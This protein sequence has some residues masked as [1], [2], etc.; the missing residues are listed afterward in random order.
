LPNTRLF[1]IGV[2]EADVRQAEA[3][4][5]L[6]DL[7]RRIQ[8]RFEA[9][10]QVRLVL[11]NLRLGL[12][13]RLQGDIVQGDFS[14][15]ITGDL[16]PGPVRHAAEITIDA[17]IDPGVGPRPQ[18]NLDIQVQLGNLQLNDLD[19]RVL[20]SSTY[21]SERDCRD[22][23]VEVGGTCLDPGGRCVECRIACGGITSTAVNLITGLLDL[24]RPV[25]NRAIRPVVQNLIGETLRDLNGQP[26]RFEGQL[27][28]AELAGFDFLSSSPLGVYVGPRSGRFPVVDRNGLGMEVTVNAGAEGALAE[29]VGE[30]PPFTPMKGPV[31]EL[32]GTDSDGRPYH[33]GAT[34]AASYFNQI[35]YAA[36]RSGSLCLQLSSEDVR[37]L[38]NG[39]F[40]LNASLLSIIASDLSALA[41]DTAPVIVEL[42]PREPGQV[43]LGSGMQTGMDAMGNPTYDW[44]LQLGLNDLGVA[45][46]VLVEDR[47]VRAFEVSSDVFVGMNVVVQPDNSL[48]LALGELR[49]D[50]FEETFNELLPNADFAELLP[51]LLDLALGALLEQSLTFD[52]DITDAVSDALGGAPVYLRVNDIFRDG[53]MQDY[54]TMSLTFTSSRTASFFRPVD[55]RARLAPDPDLVELRPDA[56][57]VA[58]DEAARLGLLRPSGRVRL[59]VGEPGLVSGLE[60]QVRVDGGM[61]TVPRP[62]QPDGTLHLALPRLAMPGHHLLEVRARNREAYESLDPTPASVEVTVDPLPPSLS[63]RWTDAGLEVRVRDAQTL[64]VR[65]LSLEVALDDAAPSAR[66]L[67]PWSERGARVV[68]PYAEILGRDVRLVGI[69]GAGHRSAPVTLRARAVEAASAEHAAEGCTDGRL[70]R[71]TSGLLFGLLLAAL[72]GL[73]CRRATR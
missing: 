62:A 42:Q 24:I 32:A 16:G 59:Q 46:H 3:L 12:D 7:E 34:L 35:L 57:D 52:L 10:N 36:H 47:Y 15:P 60:Y 67:E 41:S 2:A 38:T 29:C 40:Q 11:T 8:L 68:L 30:L 4:I 26:A 49:I 14:C 23:A 43:T 44:L 25:I 53:M 73:R 56:L 31:P 58:P 70:P 54:L 18:Q 22:C 69:D 64:D 1:D 39:A 5:W 71:D 61:W 37:E 63:A 6:D 27:S 33:V 72:A 50:G 51:T 13:A 19:L 20:G 48:Q 45:F 17:T 21:C 66:A 9:P 55:T 28:I 65:A